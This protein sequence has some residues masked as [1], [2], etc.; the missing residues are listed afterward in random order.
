V[1]GYSIIILAL[2][3]FNYQNFKKLQTVV[4]ARRVG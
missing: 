2:I 1:I 3:V 4:S